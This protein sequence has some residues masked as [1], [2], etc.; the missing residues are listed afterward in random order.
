MSEFYVD[1][2]CAWRR[3]LQQVFGSELKVCLD[4]F[5]AVKRVGEKIPKRHPLRGSCMEE[6][7]MVFRDPSDKGK[8][9][10][11]MTPSPDVLL[12]NVQKFNQRWKHVQ[13]DGVPV[14][15]AG[16]NKEIEN[17][18]KHMQKGCLS[19]IRPGRGTSRNESLHKNLN[20]I[21]SSSR[22]GVELAYALFTVCFFNH[23][24]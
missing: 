9:R 16:A 8:E 17:I 14:L 19:G 5:H 15:N 24:E 3:Q 6:W 13:F 1:N 12:S 21:M 10:H 2:C 7:Q 23:N 20:S 22:Y 18:Q 11:M 4:I